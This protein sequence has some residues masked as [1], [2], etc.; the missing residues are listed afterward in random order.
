MSSPVILE[1][2]LN[3]ST[4]RSRNRQ[5]PRTSAEIAEVALQGI[6][7]GA[8]IVHHH[9]DEPMFTADGVHSA[10]P[11]LVAWRPILERRPDALLYP[12]MGAGA[13]GISVQRRWAHVERL[14]R[15]GG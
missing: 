7:L 9:N 15:I 12:T 3:G 10:E 8:S 11:Y 5:V 4:P 1:L 2:A 14:A 6:E 13:R